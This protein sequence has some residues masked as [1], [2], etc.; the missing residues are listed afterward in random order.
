[1]SPIPQSPEG[2]LERAEA[3]AAA[4]I[5]KGKRWFAEA[6]EQTKRDDEDIAAWRRR[7]AGGYNEDGTRASFTGESDVGGG[8]N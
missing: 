3:D 8:G 4:L 5:E 6:R 1:M 7:H 2:E